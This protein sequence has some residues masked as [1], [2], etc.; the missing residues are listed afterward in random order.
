MSLGRRFDSTGASF[1]KYLKHVERP[2]YKSRSRLIPNPPYPNLKLKPYYV[3]TPIFYPNASESVLIF[4]CAP[5]TIF[6][7]TRIAPHIGHLYSL[8]IVDIYARN[9]RCARPER[10]V[11]FT[12]GTDEHGM[13]IQKAAEERGM[14]PKELCDL[15]SDAFSVS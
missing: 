2:W 10:R 5:L 13:K 4:L 11:R 15:L 8:V 14:R 12:T 9:S 1:R 6:P 7:F 3:T